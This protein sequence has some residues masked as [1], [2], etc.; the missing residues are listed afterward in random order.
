MADSRGHDNATRWLSAAGAAAALL[1]LFLHA[2][3]G[4]RYRTEDPA[5]DLFAHQLSTLVGIT[6]GSFL[7]TAPDHRQWIYRAAYPTMLC[8]VAFP[9]MHALAAGGTTAW[10]ML[11]ALAPV[12]AAMVGFGVT[13]ALRVAAAEDGARSARGK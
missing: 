7:T 12:G 10:R 3:L 2:W 6:V 13:W 1:V 9:W 5:G 8:G 4:V 11:N